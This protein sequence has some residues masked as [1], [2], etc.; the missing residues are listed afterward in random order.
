MNINL[1]ARETFIGNLTEADIRNR[2][3]TDHW[4]SKLLAEIV[5]STYWGGVGVDLKELD[6]LHASNWKLAMD[7]MSYRRVTGW[8]DEKFY[9]LACWC[10]IQHDLMAYKNSDKF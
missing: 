6:R 7:V 2:I 1:N 3:D 10:R 9:A 4:S 5:C 8:S